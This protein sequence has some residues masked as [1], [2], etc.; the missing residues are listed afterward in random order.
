[1]CSMDKAFGIKDDFDTDFTDLKGARPQ[2]ASD[3]NSRGERS[4]VGFIAFPQLT[5]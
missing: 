3:V 5:E 1:M 4:L 2:P